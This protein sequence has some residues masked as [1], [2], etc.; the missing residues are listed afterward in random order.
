VLRAAV[1]GRV[2]WRAKGFAILL[3][4]QGQCTIK[5][6]RE[7]VALTQFDRVL[8]PDG[9]SEFEITARETAL[10]LECR[11]PSQVIIKASE[12]ID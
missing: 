5:T 7:E 10:F 1:N 4:V 6:K 3:V 9:F 8:I 11:P 12:S 2:P